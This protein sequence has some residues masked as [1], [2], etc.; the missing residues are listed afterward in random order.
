MLYIDYYNKY[1]LYKPLL[2]IIDTTTLV[3]LPT[4]T[5]LLTLTPLP[6]LA[7]ISSGILVLLLFIEEIIPRRPAVNVTPYIQVSLLLRLV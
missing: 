6:T 1:L 7:P 5:P 2:E 4:L 3:S